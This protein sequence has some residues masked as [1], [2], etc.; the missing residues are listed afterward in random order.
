MLIN[1]A[2]GFEVSE[3]RLLT[4]NMKRDYPELCE[5]SDVLLK[6]ST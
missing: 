6:E 1:I 3:L 5:W 4:D 2:K